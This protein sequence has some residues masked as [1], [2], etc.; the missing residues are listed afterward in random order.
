MNLHIK[1][2]AHIITEQTIPSLLVSKKRDEEDKREAY[3]RSKSPQKSF[4]QYFRSPS[5]DRTKRYDTRY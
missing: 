2:F 5:N 1:N 4:V 3:A